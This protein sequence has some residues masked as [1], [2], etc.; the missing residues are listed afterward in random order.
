M[1]VEKLQKIT[2]L[3]KDLHVRGMAMDM[4]E[5][6]RMADD[7]IDKNHGLR[8]IQDTIDGGSSKSSKSDY[9]EHSEQPDYPAAPAQNF[10][11]NELRLR[12]SNL[13]MQLEEQTNEIRTMREEIGRFK[14]K[15]E[16]LEKQRHE[17]KIIM[18]KSPHN[19]Q[20][21]LHTEQVKKHEPHPKVGDFNSGD[22]SVENI[23]YSGPPRD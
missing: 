8:H 1:D 15:I 13:V 12:V 14:S 18:E 17:T 20:T 10:R 4:E 23:F 9:R 3:A 6:T 11:D 22:V 7:M 2:Q 5:A 16:L 21:S 19:E